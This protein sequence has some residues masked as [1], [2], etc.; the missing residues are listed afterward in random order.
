M[1]SAETL[2]AN[3][4]VLGTSTGT[5]T[6]ATTSGETYAQLATAI[7]NATISTSYDSTSTGL[8]NTTPLTA[9]SVTTIQDNN[10]GSKFVYTA[11][12]GNTVADLNSAIAKAVTVG[13]L[14]SNVTGA[15]N[16]SGQE[17]ISE[18]A[19]DQGITVSTNDTAL[20]AINADPAFTNPLGLTATATTD[21]SGNTSLTIADT[22]GNAPFTI[23]EPSSSTSGSAFSFTQAVQGANASL[24]VDGVPIVSASNTVTG[25]IP[26][27]TLSLLGAAPGSQIAL[28][29]ASDA[30]QVSTAINQ[31]V[32]D[33]NTAIGLV[34]AQFKFSST[35]NA[36]GVLGSDPTVRALQS[37]LEQAINYANTPATGTTTVSS[38]SDLGI[39][40]N[41]DGTLS[42]DSSTLNAALVNNPSDVQNFFEGTALN[43]FANT[44]NNALNTFTSPANGAF[45]VDLSSIS[46]TSSA[47]TSQ[48]NNFETG[49]IASQQTLLTADYTAAEVAL[50]QLPQEMAELNSELGFTSKSS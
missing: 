4:L 18:G 37:T 23:N 5:A 17:V 19:T 25:S 31:F 7:N 35:T 38:L 2:G 21:S 50:Q 32:T 29:V 8:T 20:G 47:L 46:S 13:T 45:T 41:N 39:T 14:S 42:V 49:Y 1:T 26:G 22:T 12:A 10:S 9:G 16:A 27:V 11:V 28:T 40:M 43:G 34:N 15:I 36:Q 3:N 33:F 24:T 6:I 48:I 30:S 44:V